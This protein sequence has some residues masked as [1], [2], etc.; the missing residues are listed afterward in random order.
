MFRETYLLVK[1]TFVT[2]CAVDTL[3][4]RMFAITVT[5]ISVNRSSLV[6]QPERRRTRKRVSKISRRGRG[7]QDASVESEE[8]ELTLRGD[9][10]KDAISSNP[11]EAHF[12]GTTELKAGGSPRRRSAPRP[13]RPAPMESRDQM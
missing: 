5:R 4:H 6:D 8:L 7:Q 13:I 10:S 1:V 11:S 2:R 9:V 12:V 3:H